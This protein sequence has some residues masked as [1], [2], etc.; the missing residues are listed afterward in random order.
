MS[1]RLLWRMARM[2]RIEN[3]IPPSH[4]NP[5]LCD[6][7]AIRRVVLGLIGLLPAVFVTPLALA[8]ARAP[9]PLVPSSAFYVGL[10]GGYSS[11][12]FST[13]DVYMA[14]TSDSYVG[15]YLVQSGSAGGSAS[16]GMNAQSVFAPS[17]QGGYFQHFGTSHWMWGAKFAYT[18]LGANSTVSPALVP[19]AGSYTYTR[20]GITLPLSGNVVIGSYQATLNHQFALLPFFGYSFNRGYVY[21]GAGP[22][23]SEMQTKLSRVVG[24]AEIRGRPTDV[25]GRAVDYSSSGWVVGGAL[26]VGGTYFLNSSWFLDASYSFAVTSSLD[27]SYFAPFTNT[28]ASPAATVTGTLAGT[29]SGNA[30]I[31]AITVSINKAF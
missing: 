11:V 5:R 2:R 10:G 9:A 27:S 14:G 22:T 12:R 24:F 3:F 26:A 25:S 19:Q 15:D 17:V 30:T 23:V 7:R 6:A 18:Y 20:S 21:F 16:I 13:Q 31:Q 4:G 28:H 29:S 8:Q 1:D